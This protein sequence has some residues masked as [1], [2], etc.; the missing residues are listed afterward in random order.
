MTYDV[1]IV[2][3]GPAGS[4]AATVLARAGRTVLLLDRE[5]FPRPKA[6]GD[7]IGPRA[8]GAMQQIG[9]APES[10]GAAFF[11]LA[12]SLMGAPGGR[13][14]AVRF[15]DRGGAQRYGMVAR[16][17]LDDT[18]RRH[19]VASGAEQQTM[20]VRE[21]RIAPGRPA[22]LSGEQDGQT[23]SIEARLVIGADGASS[24]VARALGWPLPAPEHRGVAIR[25][26]VQRRGPM[27]PVAELYFL[28]PILPGYAWF[29]PASAETVN[30]GVGIRSDFY[31]RQGRHLRE[32]LAQFLAMPAIAERVVAGS[33]HETSSWALNLGSQPGSRV[34][35]GALLAGDAGAFVDPLVGA[36][37]HTALIT[38]QL[39][40]EV[41]LAALRSG[42]LSRRGLAAYDRRWR[43]LLERDFRLEHALQ[44]V[45]ARA[46]ALVDLAAAVLPPD[47]GLI[48]FFLKKL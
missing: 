8:L 48:H 14:I 12:R 1:A 43:A 20:L 15:P 19:A 37:I 38:G 31:K 22:T 33:L 23:R 3:S 17:T 26:Y 46:P 11:P 7:L 40:G 21:L 16:E 41:A 45:V 42:D 39:A 36:G 28:K 35:D 2:G 27:A 34:F 32:M 13:T 47:S 10:L 30:V 4:A 29:F 25:G 18:L 44:R 5:A 9:L 6:C 24:L